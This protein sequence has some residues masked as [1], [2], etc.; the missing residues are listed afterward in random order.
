M[1]KKKIKPETIKNLAVGSAIGII[2]TYLVSKYVL[3]YDCK[4]KEPAG[5]VTI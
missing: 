4:T 5:K 1:A 2:G 3:K